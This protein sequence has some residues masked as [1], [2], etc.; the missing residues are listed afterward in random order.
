[1]S[2][3]TWESRGLALILAAAMVYGSGVQKLTAAEETQLETEEEGISQ[4]ETDGFQGGEEESEWGE[5]GNFYGLD[6]KEPG[7]ENAA[8]EQ[9]AEETWYSAEDGKSE[10]P[11]LYDWYSEE[12]QE[13]VD[14]KCTCIL[15]GE[16]IDIL[17]H[18]DGCQAYEEILEKKCTCGIS[19]S[20]TDH[21]EECALVTHM[22]ETAAFMDIMPYAVTSGTGISSGQNGWT[23]VDSYDRVYDSSFRQISFHSNTEVLPFSDVSSAAAES[24][25]GDEHWFVVKKEGAAGRIG[26]RVTNVAYQD[27]KAIDAVITLAEFN[28]YV[29]SM[30][31]VAVKVMTSLG[32]RKQK[33]YTNGIMLQASGGD[34]ALRV[35]L[36]E[37]GTSN[38]I[39]GNYG[40]RIGNINYG[41][42]YGI[43]ARS[44]LTGK[45]SLTGKYATRDCSLSYEKYQTLGIDWDMINAPQSGNEGTSVYLE[46]KNTSSFYFFIGAPGDHEN[47]HPGHRYSKTGLEEKRKSILDHNFSDAKPVT[48]SWSGNAYGP[49]D[50][51]IHKFVSSSGDNGRETSL[52]L[53]TS[54]ASFYYDLEMYVPYD[55]P[56]NTAGCAYNSLWITD[57]LPVGIDYDHDFSVWD[58]LTGANRT[59]WFTLTDNYDTLT[60]SA[61]AAALADPGFYENTYRIK[62]RAKMDPAEKEPERNGDSY[63]YTAVNSGTL[64]V[65]HKNDTRGNVAIPTGNASTVYRGT[66]NR[67][68]GVHKYISVSGGNWADSGNVADIADAFSYNMTVDVPYNEYGGFADHFVVTDTLPAG[69]AF[70]DNSFYAVNEDGDVTRYF[71]ASFSGRTLTV[72][73]SAGALASQAFYGKH[74][75]LVFNA[76]MLHSEMTPEYRGNEAVFTARN[77]FGLAIKHKADGAAS[78]LHSNIV[79]VS[80]SL[81]RTDPPSP[82]KKVNGKDSAEFSGRGLTAVFSVTQAIPAYDRCWS[83]SSFGFEDV[84]ESCFE[85]QSAKV[86]VNQVEKASFGKN[87]GSSNGWNLSVDGQKVSV[88]TENGVADGCYGSSIRLE[89]TVKLKAGCSLKSYYVSNSNAEILESHIPNGATT[90]F[91]WAKNGLESLTKNTGLVQVIVKETTPKGRISV[92]KTS[93]A[94]SPLKGAVYRITA[95]EDILSM[96]GKVLMKAG[97]LADTVTTDGDGNAVTKGLYVGKYTVTE[98]LPPQGYTRNL[99][100]TDVEIRYTESLEAGTEE[101]V[102]FQNKETLVYLKKVSELAPGESEALPLK[103][104]GFRIWN[105]TESEGQGK[106]YET[107]ERGL[108]EL[109][110]IKPGTYCYREISVPVGYVADSRVREFVMD[111]YGQV[112]KEHGHI[113]PVENLFIKAEFLKTDKVTGQALPGAELQLTDKSGTVVDTWISETTPHR[114]NR[115]PKGTY[116]LTELKAPEGYKEGRPVTC[117][118]SAASDVQTYKMTDAKYVNIRLTK[119]IY[120]NEIVMAHG[121]PVFIFQVTGTDVDGDAYTWYNTAEFSGNNA[122]EDGIISMFVD[123][124]VPAGVYTASELSTA[125]YELEA[126]TGALNGTA[127]ENAVKFDLSGNK[128][129]GAVFTN[130]KIT[131]SELTDTALVRNQVIQEK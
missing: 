46:V 77:Q 87:S 66:I 39:T 36:V 126:I 76:R 60:I 125:R 17:E 26:Y 59:G 104:V 24:V 120:A 52:T 56:S 1:M 44:D 50:P 35:D 118:I 23:I 85:L 54:T 75:N 43:C 103:G 37:H 45:N 115:I 8:A 88:K 41:Q 61:T 30:G 128:N 86:Y 15:K 127:S 116:T 114:I 42:R 129:G 67:Q 121:N 105:K 38:R 14:E 63:T 91:Q 20:I 122:A 96:A 92:K 58:A 7:E 49:K 33:F 107:D 32:I 89:M 101:R 123:F 69:L 47:D 34:Q 97:S 113:I 10:E 94:G 109:K 53:N 21:K 62:V 68:Y 95:K 106:T 110:G 51:V 80:G 100:P 65:N 131:D 130:K 78:S 90:V 11:W 93:E 71:T 48:V 29:Y 22:R 12:F 28:P 81:V 13:W 108:I 55:E 18:D 102:S 19:G 82:V 40:F 117:E 31:D 9:D 73:A 98:E 124:Q 4:E 72:T 27:G 2:R 83:L 111:E 119:R 3:K 84:L 57:A 16:G 5:S 64:Y 74:Y 99:S 79:P 112:E 70:A 6:E 25:D